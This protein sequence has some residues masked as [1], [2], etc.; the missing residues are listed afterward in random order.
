[1]SRNVPMLE[2]FQQLGAQTSRGEAGTVVLDLPL[3]R[4]PES[5]PDS[6]AGRVLKSVAQKLVP[7]LLHPL[8]R[9]GIET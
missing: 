5:V 8:H 3:P 6:P 2:I 7:D 1:M 4:D 9:T